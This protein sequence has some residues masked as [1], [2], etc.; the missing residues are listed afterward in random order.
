MCRSYCDSSKV[1]E[2]QGSHELRFDDCSVPGR[3][4]DEPGFPDQPAGPI[5][6]VEILCFELLMS[7]K[8][9]GKAGSSRRFASSTVLG[10]VRKLLSVE[11]G[12]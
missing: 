8:A 5:V 3:Q 2:T 12:R 6:E 1:G 10:L 4:R 9:H 7:H 11:S